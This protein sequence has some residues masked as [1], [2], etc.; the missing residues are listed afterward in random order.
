MLAVSGTMQP[1]QVILAKSLCSPLP[2]T[3]LAGHVDATVAGPD[4]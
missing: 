3:C 1:F 2:T 4:S